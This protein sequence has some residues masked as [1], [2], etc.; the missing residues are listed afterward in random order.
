MLLLQRFRHRVAHHDSL[1]G[2]DVQARLEDMPTI[3]GWIDPAARAWLRDRTD[4]VAI[5]HG[6]P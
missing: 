6:M 3:A 4:A 5:T 1:L 2:Q